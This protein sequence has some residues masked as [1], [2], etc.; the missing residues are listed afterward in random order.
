MIATMHPPRPTYLVL[1]IVALLCTACP[2]KTRTPPEPPEVVSAPADATQARALA[3]PVARAEIARV[4]AEHR[5]DN[6]DVKLEWKD[7]DV[8]VTEKPEHF[9]V[10]YQ[11]SNPDPGFELW[12]GHGMHFNVYV[13]RKTGKTRMVGGE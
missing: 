11:Y 13:D 12:A 1:A 9:V 10:F 8:T 6:P 5:K 3:D 2:D 4:E 7:Y